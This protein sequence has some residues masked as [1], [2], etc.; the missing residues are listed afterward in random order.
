MIPIAG[1]DPCGCWVDYIRHEYLGTVK[2]Y[3][4]SAVQVVVRWYR[5]APNAKPLGKITCFG[6]SWYTQNG[7]YEPEQGMTNTW[8]PVDQGNTGGLLGV[9]PCGTNET[10]LNGVSRFNP[11][12]PCDCVREDVVPVQE[13]PAG[14]V[15]GVN[16]VFTTSQIPMSSDSHLLFV[17]G[18]E[19]DQGTNYSIVAQT[20]F[21]TAPSTPTVG[22]NI[23]SY[24][25][26]QT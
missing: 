24:Y 16:R 21:F 14:L 5:A 12:P 3:S 25:W 8:E 19:Q 13:T 22:S 7:Y 23:V 20:I 2:P 10:W 18:V 17:N 6:D 9:A 1:L 11:P 26:V 15:D 4:D